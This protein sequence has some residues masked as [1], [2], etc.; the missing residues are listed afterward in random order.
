[1]QKL[2]SLIAL[3]AIIALTACAP[4]T[5]ESTPV[6]GPEGGEGE[7]E[8]TAEPDEPGAP[9]EDEGDVGE[10]PLPEETGPEPIE[11][12]PTRIGESLSPRL[13][14]RLA[15]IVTVYQDDGAGPAQDAA[16]SM[17]I[18]LDGGRVMVMV[19]VA[20]ESDVPVATRVIGAAGGTI[21]GAYAGQIQA[22]VPLPALNYIASEPYVRAVM[23]AAGAV[24]AP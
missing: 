15:Q 4:T 14:S 1:M 17:G 21:V 10:T 7:P 12:T 6:G 18:Q 13:E 2:G 16:A 23:A 19:A 20:S 9:P 11:P 5:A 3:S 22:W 24:P 8:M